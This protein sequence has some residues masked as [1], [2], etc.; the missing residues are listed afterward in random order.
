MNTIK[1]VDARLETNQVSGIGNYI[2]DS[3][4]VLPRTNTKLYVLI[5]EQASSRLKQYIADQPNWIA[6]TCKL[7]PYNII[8][9]FFFTFWLQSKFKSA[10]ITML[11]FSYSTGLP[12]SKINYVPTVH[13]LAFW[14]DRNY[15]SSFIK[16][17]I[18]KLYFYIIVWISLYFARAVVTISEST[19]RDIAALFRVNSL[20]SPNL[21]DCTRT[22]NSIFND[23]NKYVVYIGNGRKHKNL[24]FIVDMCKET[25]FLQDYCIYF[26]GTCCKHNDI[27][28]LNNRW[29]SEV[30]LCGNV[31]EEEKWQLLERAHGLFMFSS[32][33][34]FG[35]PIAEA[36]VANTRVYCSDIPIF[37][38]FES[39]G[40]NY[41][42]LSDPNVKAKIYEDLKV[43]K[44]QL[45]QFSYDKFECKNEKI[46]TF[47]LVFK[48]A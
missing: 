26:V 22:N 17:S 23:V 9:F 43:D 45:F 15:F 3:L 34:G 2:M 28:E 4:R 8:H 6:V 31:T 29:P 20:I 14:F 21:I 27:I 24:D 33:E 25:Q 5:S 40:I 13:D 12:S 48:D 18:G 38:E 39:N 30:K 37:R 32:Y 44:P 42:R 41:Y 36:L 47:E 7:W 19:Q 10:D 16:R 1:I 35:I 46:K 11:S